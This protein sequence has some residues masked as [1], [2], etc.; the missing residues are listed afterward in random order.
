MKWVEDILQLV[1]DFVSSA[2]EAAR[3]SHQQDPGAPKAQE[4]A[5]KDRHRVEEALKKHAG[6][7]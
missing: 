3:L 6:G 5:V 1:D 7:K 4:Q 2:V